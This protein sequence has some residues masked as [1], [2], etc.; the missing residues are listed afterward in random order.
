[1]TIG[2][3][4]VILTVNFRLLGESVIFGAGAGSDLLRSTASKI[5]AFQA[6]AFD[7]VREIG[8][9]VIGVGPSNEVMN[10]DALLPPGSESFEPWTHDDVADHLMRVDLTGISGHMISGS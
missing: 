2:A 4:P 7:H 8:W 1:M 5:V 10:A 6:V 3:L 9:E